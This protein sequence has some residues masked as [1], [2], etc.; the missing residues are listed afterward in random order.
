MCSTSHTTRSAGDAEPTSRVRG[1]VDR[2]L[3]RGDS[4]D[5]KILA[6]LAYCD[7]C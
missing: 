5:R 3:L 6:K 7:F 1:S 4:K 2:R